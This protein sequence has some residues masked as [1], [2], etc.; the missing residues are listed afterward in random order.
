MSRQEPDLLICHVSDLHFGPFLQGVSRI[1]E[2]SSIAAPH[3]YYML[4][5][6]EAALGRILTDDKYNDRLIVAV[7]GDM[8]TA[9]EPPAYE[10]VNNYIRDNPFVASDHRIGLRLSEKLTRIYFV[11]GNHDMWLY[12]SLLTRWKNNPDR[13]DQYCRYFPERL[14]NAYPLVVN[15][16]SITIFTLDTN[17]VTKVNW[18]NFKNVLGRGEVGKAQIADLNMLDNELTTKKSKVPE[19]FDY[20]GSL[21]IALM[22]HHLALPANIPDDL[23]QKFLQ[24]E[25]AE[26]VTNA[27]CNI[28]IDLVLCGHQHFPYQIPELTSSSQTGHKIFLSCAGSATQLQCACNSFTTYEIR[29]RDVGFSLHLN[30]YKA[31]A[32]VDA[33]FRTD[34][35][36]DYII[37]VP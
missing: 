6:M 2:W 27:L 31:D 25:D 21:K 1:G 30:A 8:T 13:R 23:E 19:G 4:N 32:S 29:K 9:A 37:G 15:G 22:H 3:D 18:F 12:G 33:R 28:G 24:L 10:S 11:P 17:R 34:G 16:L 5:G 35:G 26:L 36:Q 20:E 14:P 7:T